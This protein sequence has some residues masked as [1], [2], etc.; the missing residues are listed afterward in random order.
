MNKLNPEQINEMR[1]QLRRQITNLE[2]TIAEMQK[3]FTDGNIITPVENSVL[4]QYK[5]KVFELLN[6]AIDS[7]V[8]S[9]PVVNFAAL[10]SSLLPATFIMDDKENKKLLEFIEENCLFYQ[11][12][13]E[14]DPNA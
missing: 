3:I 12:R 5:Y 10:A 9:K 14:G 4:N 7:E 2:S 6:L 11:N 1:K 8:P 13:G